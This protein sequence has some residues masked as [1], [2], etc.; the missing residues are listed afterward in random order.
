MAFSKGTRCISY[1]FDDL[2]G[3][4]CVA[5]LALLSMILPTCTFI[6]GQ[7]FK[8]MVQSK[9]GRSDTFRKILGKRSHEIAIDL[10][11]QK[12]KI[13]TFKNEIYLQASFSP[14]AYYH[15]DVI[16]KSSSNAKSSS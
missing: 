10:C 6:N 5:F 7:V 14:S 3:Y 4:N 8:I 12:K 13:Q 1:P 16:I 2:Q 11:K 15:D 9:D